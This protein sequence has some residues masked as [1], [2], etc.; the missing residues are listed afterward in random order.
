[1]PRITDIVSTP[2]INPVKRRGLLA[3]GNWI[4]DHVKMIDVWPAQ[5]ALANIATQSDGNGGG[6][7][8]ITKNLARLGCGFSLAGVGLLGHDDDGGKILRD[9]AEHGIDGDA[10]RQTFAAP[11]SYTDVMTVAGTGRRTFFHQHGANALLDASHFELTKSSARIFYLGYLCLLRTLDVV[12]AHGRTPASRLFEQARA[13]GM[14]TVAD[15]VSNE[16]G[17]FAAIVN[18]SLPHLD[19][20]FLN[21]YELARLIGEP[22]VKD[23]ALL[24]A[25]AGEVLQRGVHGAVI[26]H[27]PEG[28]LCVAKERPAV[29]Q[30]AVRMPAKLI[31]GTAGAGD[32]FGAGF[33]LGLHEGWDFPRCLE[34]AVCAA[35]VSLRDATCSAAIEPWANCLAL[36]RK[37]GFYEE[38]QIK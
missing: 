22:A 10:L 18:P 14:I 24:E 30:P 13:A 19:Y 28:A 25:Q 12:D 23:P 34:L 5:D 27:L 31:A 21:E 7:Y 32:A 16:A 17:D 37:M 9:C 20:L 38:V 15:L 29:W 26:V 1:M 6:P 3:G 8:N 35:A 33:L 4:V 2:S 11:T 36:G